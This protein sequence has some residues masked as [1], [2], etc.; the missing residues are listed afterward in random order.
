MAAYDLVI[1]G[2]AVVDGTGGAA[3]RGDVAVSDGAHRRGRQGR[4]GRRGGDRRRAAA[5]STPGFVDIHTHYDGQATWDAR[6]QPSSLARRD[7]R[8][9]GQLRRRLRALPARRSRAADPADG[10]RRG[11]PRPGARRGPAVEL[12]ELPGISR[13]PRAPRRST[14]TSAASCRTRPLRVYVMGERGADREPATRGG[15][16]RDGGA[17]PGGD[18]GRRARL[19]HLAHAQPPHQRRRADP[20]LTAGED[21]LTGIAAGP[22]RP[23]ARACCRWSPTSPIRGRSSRCCGGSSRR[24][25]RPL[26]FTLVQSPLRSE[27]PGAPARPPSRTRSPRGLPIKAQV[28]GA[29]GRRAAGLRADAESVQPPSDLSRDRPLCPL[30]ERVARLRDPAVRAPAAGRAAGRGGA[31]LRRRPGASMHLLADPP[32]YEPRRGSTRRRPRARRAACRRRKSALDPCSE[33]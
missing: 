29:A 4:R 19:H 32:D 27:T 30:A 20:D 3:V 16:R 12:G 18:G 10:R 33:Q 14:S 13:R 21:E 28:G 22:R 26:S 9:D 25:G 15:H 11:H 6:M 31:R 17:G 5:S 24:S 2:G 1:R 23:R 7:H 8:G